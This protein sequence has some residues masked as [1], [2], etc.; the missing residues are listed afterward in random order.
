MGLILIVMASLINIIIPLEF[1][2]D[3]FNSLI[4]KSAMHVY[5][6]TRAGKRVTLKKVN[7]RE[8]LF[9]NAGERY[10]SAYITSVEFL[11][12]RDG[13]IFDDEFCVHAIEMRGGR[14]TPD[15]LENLSL[16][17]ISK[18]PDKN[19]KSFVNKLQQ[20]LKKS[21]NYGVGVGD[22]WLYR[23]TFYHRSEILGKTLWFDSDRKFQPLL[24]D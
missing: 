7:R 12:E 19:I 13:D 15:E 9:L 3:E 6:K 20:H 22:G 21:D 14:S 11:K 5:I 8:D 23:R 18:T 1:F 2:F 17:V 10:S 4:N 24:V 16:R